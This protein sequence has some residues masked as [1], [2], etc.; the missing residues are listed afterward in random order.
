[1]EIQSMEQVAK[2]RKK[3]HEKL[4]RQLAEKVKIIQRSKQNKVTGTRQFYE[5]NLTNMDDAAL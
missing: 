3:H 2:K 5:A 1:M 4:I